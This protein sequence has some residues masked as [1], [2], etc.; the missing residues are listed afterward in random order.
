MRKI[1]KKI[2][3][4]LLLFTL[5]AAQV[6]F[7]KAPAIASDGQGVITE[8]EVEVREGRG[9]VLVTTE[10]LIGV[11]TQNSEKLAVQIAQNFTG[12]NI[13]DKDVIFTFFA[14]VSLVDG[15]SA[16]AAMAV[17][18]IAAL[19]ENQVNQDIMI[20]GSI[21]PDGR[22]GS[23]GGILKKVKAASDYGVK[24]FLI[25]KG[26]RTITDYVKRVSNPAPG[27][28]V[29]TEEPI[30]I[31]IS[32][33]AEQW[34]MTIIEIEYIG[35]SIPFMIG[36]TKILPRELEVLPL[37]NVEGSEPLRK[38]AEYEIERTKKLGLNVSVSE[39]MFEKG[40]YYA[41]ANQAFQQIISLTPS[42]TI[43]DLR[44]N[45][46]T[47]L[48]QVELK[49]ESVNRT[50]YYLDDLDWLAAAEQR[51]VQALDRIDSQSTGDLAAAEEWLAL[52]EF[53][54]D[55]LKNRG[56]TIDASQVQLKLARLV[57]EASRESM[58]SQALGEARAKQSLDLAVKA[59]EKGYQLGALNLAADAI[60]IG[61]AASMD[62]YIS[63]DK[64]LQKKVSGD[65]ATAYMDNAKYLRWQSGGGDRAL[66]SEAMYYSVR[67]DTYS[68]LYTFV[69][70]PTFD[71]PKEVKEV[72]AVQ[73]EIL[74]AIVGAYLLGMF[75]VYEAKKKKHK[76]FLKE[77]VAELRNK[78]DV[79]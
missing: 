68:S 79:I 73:N 66:L 11:D 60:A 67:A 5:A 46:R 13:S 22:V 39:Y 43:E 8:V 19:Q 77:K 52:A 62:P 4:F 38:M 9:R 32:T 56:D 16:G 57:N 37:E 21:A 45:V 53:S 34:G 78:I 12:V 63:L 33:F 49:L 42:A 51:Y 15:P 74:L 61:E 36:D 75:A 35:E 58:V 27:V 50:Y 48:E 6:V 14:N 44:F 65:W 7:I 55:Q 72:E 23:V 47:H 69:S 30:T 54:I 25:P 70:M 41:S 31:D 76:R 20:T 17:A 24:T 29:E 59:S 2:L 10:P 64:Q 3:P 71:I 18:T 40:Y 1:M 26:Q 28:Y